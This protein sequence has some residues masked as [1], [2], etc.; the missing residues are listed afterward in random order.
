MPVYQDPKTK[1]YYFSC[2]FVD[3]QGK[4]R[5]KVK[6]GFLLARDAKEAEREFLAQYASECNMS[7]SAFYK[8][9]LDDCKARLKVN[10]VEAKDARFRT[11]ILPYFGDF[12]IN[13]IT[14]AQVRKWQNKIMQEYK[15]T[16]QRQLQAQISAIFN[17][18]AKFYG[19][20]N[21]PAR[22]AGSIGSIKSG[23][24]D[25]WTLEEFNKAMA[26]ENDFTAKAA[27][28]V[29]FYSGL[30]AGELLALNVADYDVEE[31]A[32][33]INKTL[34]PNKGGFS[35]TTPKTEKSNRVVKLPLIAAKLLDEYIATLYEP[36]GDDRIFYTLN[37][38]KMRYL[39]KVDAEKAGVKVIRV[40]DLRHSHASLL[41]NNNVNIKA[42]SERLGHEDIQT[43][44]NVYSHLY[45]H[46]QSNIVSLLD[47]LQE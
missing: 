2:P 40:H 5:R 45:E 4:R 35:I 25:F 43:T 11:A 36:K 19:L 20:K 30:R 8:I 18:A 39:L 46:Q 15:P 14:P 38:Q 27:F 42:V 13:D 32:L 28:T 21:N 3:W 10:T 41:I 6:R 9:Y 33:T 47:K 1:K 17:F 31:K 23:R 34:A 29:L 22:I 16:T 24:L 26:C 44:L 7:F 12:C 37:H